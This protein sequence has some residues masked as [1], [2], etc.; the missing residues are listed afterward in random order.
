VVANPAR[1]LGWT[2]VITAAIAVSLQ[3]IDMTI[4]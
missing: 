2:Q 1:L 4:P 3:P